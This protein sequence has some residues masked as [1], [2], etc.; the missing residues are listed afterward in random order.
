[1]VRVQELSAALARRLGPALE[2]HDLFPNRT[3]VQFVKVL[4][5]HRVAIE[6]W[7]RG[8]GYTLASGSSNCAAAAASV[9]M[10]WC[11]GDVTV[12]MPGG[13]LDI[14]V[15]EDFA[16]TMLGPVAKVADGR[17]AA[18]LLSAVGAK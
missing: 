10:G 2:T 8:A 4:G 11:R 3:N 9:R 1:V 14:G 16:L 18:D 5:M 13:T 6:I 17:I 7:E 12:V 15:S